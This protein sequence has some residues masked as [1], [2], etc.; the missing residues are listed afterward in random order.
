MHIPYEELFKYNIVNYM[1]YNCEIYSA[2]SNILYYS[3][4]LL[5]LLSVHVSIQPCFVPVF[6]TCRDELNT[7]VTD[8]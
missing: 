6:K 7:I 3:L 5:F 4:L 8:R 1:C 2:G